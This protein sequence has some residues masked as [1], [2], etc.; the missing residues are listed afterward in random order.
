MAQQMQTSSLQEL[1]RNVLCSGI[2][3]SWGAVCLNNLDVLRVR[4]Q[5]TPNAVAQHNGSV[6]SFARAVVAEEGFIRGLCLPGMAA[7]VAFCAFNGAVRVGSYPVIRDSLASSLHVDSKSP[8][9]MGLAGFL[10]GA[11]GYGGASPLRLILVRLQGVDAG[12]VGADGRLLTGARK[13]QHPI[14]ISMA[15]GLKLTYKSSVRS[16]NLHFPKTRDIFFIV[17]INS[18]P[19]DASIHI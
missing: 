19:R 13:G 6:L 17:I 3:W 15:R 1:P 16:H 7:N 12:L 2:A 11:A 8:S 18:S 10:S 14:Y 4:W 9:T 5:V